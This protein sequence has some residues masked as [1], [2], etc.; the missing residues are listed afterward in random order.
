MST[1]VIEF[2][3]D[4]ILENGWVQVT[5][6]SFKEKNW[7]PGILFYPISLCLSS[8]LCL[9]FSLEIKRGHYLLF[10]YFWIEYYLNPINAVT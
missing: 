9:S 2:S 7:N 6:K 8:C 3:L 10:K 1:F 4:L 5:V